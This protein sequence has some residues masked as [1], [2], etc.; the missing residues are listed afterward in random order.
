[1]NS[2]LISFCVKSFCASVK[3]SGIALPSEQLNK[4][5]R[6]K[7]KKITDTLDSSTTHSPHS[8]DKRSTT[9]TARRPLPPKPTKLNPIKNK[10]QTKTQGSESAKPIASENKKT[11]KDIGERIG[12]KK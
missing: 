10:A 8:N 11:G 12:R 2:L 5:K 3:S 7:E 4:K 6:R 9:A 1:M